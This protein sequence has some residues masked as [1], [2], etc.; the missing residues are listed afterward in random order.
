MI[1]PHFEWAGNCRV[2]ETKLIV[3][4]VYQLILDRVVILR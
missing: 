4:G 2:E 1:Q 3:W